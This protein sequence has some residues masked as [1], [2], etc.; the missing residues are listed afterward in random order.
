MTY[1]EAKKIKERRKQGIMP[2][3]NEQIR[4][5]GAWLRL[6]GTGGCDCYPYM[7]MWSMLDDII[8]YYE[9]RD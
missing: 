2:N 4:I 9:G 5:P 8:R 3:H 7:D 6:Y 1:R